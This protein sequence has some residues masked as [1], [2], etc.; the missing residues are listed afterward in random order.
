MSLTGLKDASRNLR[1]INGGLI[2]FSRAS[3]IAWAA[4][5][6]EEVAGVLTEQ[7]RSSYTSGVSV[8]GDARTHHPGGRKGPRKA[9]QYHGRNPSGKRK[10]ATALTLIESGRVLGSLYFTSDGG[11]QVRAR[12]STKYSRYLI[13]KYGVLPCG[14]AAMPSAW[15]QAVRA[16]WLR[17]SQNNNFGYLMGV[18]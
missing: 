15:Q 4:K 12:L 6:A 17:V 16:T 7:A 8:Y 1:K 9:R 5:L 3:S 14:N 11:T 18:R 10:G 2:D 13:G